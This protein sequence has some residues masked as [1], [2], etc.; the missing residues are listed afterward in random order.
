MTLALAPKSLSSESF[1]P[2]IIL[3]SS[4]ARSSLAGSGERPSDVLADDN[5]LPLP[6]SVTPLSDVTVN[7]PWPATRTPPSTGPPEIQDDKVELR[8]LCLVPAYMASAP[9]QSHL[10]HCP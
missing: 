3:S 2:E 1:P 4:P 7:P 5:H 9:P 8:S 10:S 6:A